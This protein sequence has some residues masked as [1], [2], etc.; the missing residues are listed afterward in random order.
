MKP[1]LHCPSCARPISS[2][3]NLT[4]QVA[5]SACQSSFG[6]IYGK[7]SRCSSLQETLFYFT[8]NLPRLYKRHYTL[9][10][11]T[12]E[13]TLQQLQFSLSS[14]AESIPV[15]SGDM[16][17]V[18]YTGPVYAL[19]QLVAIANHTT[20]RTHRFLVPI[21]G[22]KY[23]IRTIG[24]ILIGLLFVSILSGINFLLMALL[25]GMGA[26]LYLKLS[27]TVQLTSPLL[28]QC[29]RE[30]NRLLSDQRLLAQQAKL[31]QRISELRCDC[32]A[33]Q[34]LI[35]Q[36]ESLKHKMNQVDPTLYS[37]RIYRTTTAIDLLKQQITNN[38]R[39]MR[40]YQRT[41]RMIEIEVE[42]S[43]VAEQLP[44]GDDF[45]RAIVEKLAELKQIEDQN[46][47]LKLRLTAY[48]DL[49]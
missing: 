41:Q 20:G 28:D 4:S 16:V 32:E 3:S 42:T 9:Q 40:E 43:W 30:G 19:R 8:N 17:S 48:Q 6:V 38:Q 23:Q 26:L 34:Q 49:G 35:R 18:F 7:L 11:T 2:S 47:S 37:S 5:C 44:D 22:F 29:G 21:P 27:H 33:N 1:S 46:E 10:I 45:S 15:R 24:A 36:L 31:E 39:L 13:R 12:P 14:N 25:G